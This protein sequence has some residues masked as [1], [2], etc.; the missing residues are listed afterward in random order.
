MIKPSCNKA[1][2]LRKVKGHKYLKTLRERMRQINER[3]INSEKKV[4]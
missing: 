2:K 1:P 4:A 3:A